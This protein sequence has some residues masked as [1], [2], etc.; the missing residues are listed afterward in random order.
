MKRKHE[1]LILWNA[2]FVKGSG[3]LENWIDKVKMF[4]IKGESSQTSKT[5]YSDLEAKS[6]FLKSK[7]EVMCTFSVGIRPTPK[8]KRTL[9]QMLKVSNYAYNWC[10]YLVKEKNFKPKQFDLQKIVTKTNAS[11]IPTEYRRPQDEWFF[12]NKMTTIKL[13][14]CKNFSAMYKSAQTNQKKS[15]V[16]LRNK[17]TTILR[18]GSFEV[19]RLYVRLLTSKDNINERFRQSRIAMMPDNFSKSRKDC[20]ERFLRISKDVSKLPPLS[21]DM[22]ISK[23]ANGKFVLHIPCD[24]ICTR[25]IHVNSTDSICSIDP[26]GRT[27]ATCYD[28]SN[29]KC[30]QVGRKEDKERI[31]YR[32]HDKIDRVHEQLS[33][34]IQ[35]NQTQAKNDRIGQLKKLHLKLKTYVNDIHL[36]L[37]SYLVKHYKLTVLGKIS[38]SSIVRKDRPKHLSKRSNRDLLCWQHYKFRER[39]LHRARD[40]NCEVIVQD[41]SYT[42]MTCGNCGVKNKQ[43]GGNETFYCDKCKY[44][45]HRDVNGARNIMLKYLNIFPFSS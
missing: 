22:K 14:A 35:R 4:E 12:D 42:S 28:P 33:L 3:T 36:K 39:L 17:D 9:N 23:R 16:D 20:K 7:D 32:L 41:E 37:C 13:T 10:N 18:E 34:A 38:V 15:R 43:L 29:L 2:A 8:Q 1:S 11:D 30:F 26:G 25:Q 5:H 21:Y 19:P 44:E 6:K 31:I 27:F 24:P 45:T 40:T